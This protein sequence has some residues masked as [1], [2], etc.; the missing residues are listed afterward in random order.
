MMSH[1]IDPVLSD[2]FEPDDGLKQNRS[3][4]FFSKRNFTIMTVGR[5]S[6]P[7]LSGSGWLSRR[8][9]GGQGR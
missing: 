9:L 3:G 2:F 5:R 8:E 7:G 1:A 4:E 6:Q